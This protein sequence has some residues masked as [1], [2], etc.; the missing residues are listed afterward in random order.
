MLRMQLEWE[1]KERTTGGGRSLWHLTSEVQVDP[2]PSIIR[3]TAI[4]ILG[5]EK[6]RYQTTK[7]QLQNLF[8]FD[9]IRHQRNL[10]TSFPLLHHLLPDS[11]Q[12]LLARL[13]WSCLLSRLRPPLELTRDRALCRFRGSEILCSDK[14]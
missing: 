5:L 10:A 11:V 13:P 14:Q 12:Y 3:A 2:I 1:E 6:S 8:Q 4:E 9:A 7:G